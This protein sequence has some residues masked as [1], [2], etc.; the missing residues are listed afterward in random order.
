[1]AEGGV[2][3][4]QKAVI[5][6]RPGGVHVGAPPGL[7]SLQSLFC[8]QGVQCL[9][10]EDDAVVGLVQTHDVGCEMTHVTDTIGIGGTGVEQAT[11]LD[12]GEDRGEQTPRVM[13]VFQGV[14]EDHRI[15]TGPI[16]G[17]LRIRLDVGIVA[18]EVGVAALC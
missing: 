7:H 5:G 9:L 12:Q 2:E 6:K 11:G 13:G 10:V 15:K 14:I 3:F 4:V 16:L 17:P 8:A 1:M 18:A